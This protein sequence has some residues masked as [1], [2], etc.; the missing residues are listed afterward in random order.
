MSHPHLSTLQAN[1]QNRLDVP[2]LVSDEKE[3]A[4]FFLHAL[5]CI[6]FFE[7]FLQEKCKNKI[8]NAFLPR[9]I[10]LFQEIF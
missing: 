2:H 10:V 6:F 3:D 1:L 5:H 8:Q 7:N 9:R 4:T